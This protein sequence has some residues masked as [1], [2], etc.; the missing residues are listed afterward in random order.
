MQFEN[1]DTPGQFFSMTCSVTFDQNSQV[2]SD[3]SIDNHYGESLSVSDAGTST[4]W[5]AIGS[6]S[7]SVLD[8]WT[9]D[10]GSVI[11]NGYKTD[12]VKKK[13]SM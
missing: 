13:K 8:W 12:Y 4:K 9:I 11:A 6:D 7:E 5:D 3:V 10:S 1:A 2:A